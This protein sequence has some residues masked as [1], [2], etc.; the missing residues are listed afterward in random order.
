V[1]ALHDRGITGKN[2]GIAI[3][4]QPLLVEHQ[5]YK[6]RLRT[7]EEIHNPPWFAQMHGPA[8]ASIAVG[9]TVGIAPGADLYY[10]AEHHANFKDGRMEM[11]V[12]PLAQSVDRILEIDASL[13]SDRKI[14]VISISFG[15]SRDLTGYDA[16]VKAA[17]RA[18][19][20]GIFV[21]STVLHETYPDS[22]AWLAGLGRDPLADPDLVAS[23]EAGRWWG[24]P[25][26]RGDKRFTGV[27]SRFARK[28]WIL[29]PMDSR[30]T[31]SPT[32]ADH[33]VFYRSGGNSWAVP[34]VAGV[35]A[36]VCQAKPDVTPEAFLA[37][38]ARTGDRLTLPGPTPPDVPAM[39][40]NPARLIAAFATK[41]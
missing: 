11:D 12:N 23:Y 13:P 33:Y 40:I 10:I 36:L 37:A 30:T 16:M 27:L 2:V 8:V 7:Y 39:V 4:D 31:A 32:G 15:W 24:L 25:M 26:A 17:D 29:A 9:K 21:V 34:Y 20:R 18:K 6:D 3:I 14:R 38:V 28:G 41:S 19:A 22:P 5:E 1:R 35:Y